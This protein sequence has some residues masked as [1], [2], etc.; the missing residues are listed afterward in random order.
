MHEDLIERLRTSGDA[1]SIEAADELERQQASLAETK[2]YCDDVTARYQRMTKVSGPA[3]ISRAE[4]AE[5]E[6]DLLRKY[7]SAAA[8]DYSEFLSL[9]E[10]SMEGE[11]TSIPV[12]ESFAELAREFKESSEFMKMA[13]EGREVGHIY[14]DELSQAKSK[15]QKAEDLLEEVRRHVS[16]VYA[17]LREPDWSDKFDIMGWLSRRP[18]PEVFR[19]IYEQ[20]SESPTNSGATDKVRELETEIAK[21]RSAAQR[22][23]P[24][25]TWTLSDE[26]PGHHPTMPSAVGAFFDSFDLITRENETSPPNSCS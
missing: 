4:K 2:E 17:W 3:L 14:D 12:L 21:L 1:L 24:Y 19:D 10:N 18:S 23:S 11:D 20:H 7:C 9:M 22:I 5:E 8:H 16:G 25:L 26:S 13:A 15:K 6:R